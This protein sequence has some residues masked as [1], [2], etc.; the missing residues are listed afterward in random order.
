MSHRTLPAV[1]ASIEQLHP[2]QDTDVLLDAIADTERREILTTLADEGPIDADVLVAKVAMDGDGDR[3][4]DG[5]GR[6]TIRFHHNHLPK[7]E[8]AGLVAQDR[9]TGLV[10]LTDAGGTV[11]TSMDRLDETL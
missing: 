10:E 11:V 1:A 6:T 5:S 4:V 8:N 9:E 3:L 2:Q 7:L